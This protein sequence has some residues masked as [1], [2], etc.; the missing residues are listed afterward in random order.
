MADAV[1]AQNYLWPITISVNKASCSASVGVYTYKLDRPVAKVFSWRIVTAVVTP[2]STDVSKAG[3]YICEHV[4]LHS[5]RMHFMASKDVVHDNICLLAR[6]IANSSYERLGYSDQV[7][8]MNPET[9]SE[10]H[11]EFYYTDGG[12]LTTPNDF[13][14][15][16]QLMVPPDNRK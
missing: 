2:H 5:Q 11:F 14:I 10:L 4:A 3:L 8:I 1:T 7:I 12:R 13:A 6:N 16:L 15:E 9:I